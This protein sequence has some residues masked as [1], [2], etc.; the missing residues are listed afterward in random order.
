MSSVLKG[1]LDAWLLLETTSTLR[2]HGQVTQLRVLPQSKH[3]H[4]GFSRWQM[5]R[6]SMQPRNLTAHLHVLSDSSI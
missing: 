1:I 3:F 5:S 2:P 6:G 4:T